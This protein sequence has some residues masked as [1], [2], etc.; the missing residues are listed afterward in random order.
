MWE[1][2]NYVGQ[3]ILRLVQEKPQGAELTK[4]Y[5][6]T[7]MS[8]VSSKV[9]A[10]FGCFVS[11]NQRSKYLEMWITDGICIYGTVFKLRVFSFQ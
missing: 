11:V 7:S 9:T 8:L 5:R 6:L 10:H 4:Y 3:Y 2:K 1:K